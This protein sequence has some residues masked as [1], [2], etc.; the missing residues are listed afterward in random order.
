VEIKDIT[1]S[2]A[3]QRVMASA[4]EAEREGRGKII[5]A[6]AER[7]AASILA[8]AAT[9]FGDNPNAMELR[10]LQTWREIASETKG[11]HTIIITAPPAG[12][13]D[14]AVSQPAAVASAL[15]RPDTHEKFNTI[16]H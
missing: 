7:T 3:L 4:T 6:E 14:A 2:K 16:P 10:R 9:S 8:D 12:G 15:I 5:A 13:H 1:I 11:T